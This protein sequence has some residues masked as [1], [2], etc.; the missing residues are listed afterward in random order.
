MKRL[1]HGKLRTSA[2]K[3]NIAKYVTQS[4][5]SEKKL[6]I[7]FLVWGNSRCS[8]E[9]HTTFHNKTD[10]SLTACCTKFNL[11]FE[12][13]YEKIIWRFMLQDEMWP[14]KWTKNEFLNAQAYNSSRSLPILIEFLDLRSKISKIGR[15]LAKMWL[16]LGFEWFS[17]L[18]GIDNVSQNLK[19]VS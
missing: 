1:L 8:H 16:F 18:V 6:W 19:L 11:T 7:S 15:V 12:P 17:P 5:T 4:A 9:F 3:V 14:K 2:E 10:Q 13:S